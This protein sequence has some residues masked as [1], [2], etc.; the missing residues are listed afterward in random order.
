[1]SNWATHDLTNVV[2][3]VLAAQPASDHHF[4][5]PYL[6]A[7]QLAIALDQHAPDVRKHLALPLGGEGTGQQTS[8]PQYLAHELSRHIT[9]DQSYPVEGAFLAPAYTTAITYTAPDGTRV[10][11]SLHRAGFPLS[12]FRLRG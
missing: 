5:R 8:F 6:T 7:Y 4:G 10:D 1:M 2:V 9:A 12:M 3:E 11:S